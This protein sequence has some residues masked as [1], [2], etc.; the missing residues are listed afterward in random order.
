MGAVNDN[1]E[2]KRYASIV[3][4][5]FSIKGKE[6]DQDENEKYT[7]MRKYADKQTGE[8]KV[9]WEWVYPAIE[10]EVVN[11][12]CEKGKFGSTYNIDITDMGEKIQV[13]VPVDSKYGTNL[14]VKVPNIK[15]GQRLRFTPYDYESKDKT[16]DFNGKPIRYSGITITPYGEKPSKENKGDQIKAYFTEENLNGMPARPSGVSEGKYKI[17]QIEK[18]EFLKE[19]VEQWASKQVFQEPQQTENDGGMTVDTSGSDDLPF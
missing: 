19:V 13:Q 10:G 15:K 3:E 18:Q 16:N 6:G 1:Y 8:E 7:V 14:A 9:L 4:G 17:Y 5:K 11:I 2:K 12:S